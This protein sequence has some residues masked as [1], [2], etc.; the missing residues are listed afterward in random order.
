[1]S[2]REELVAFAEQA[3][4]DLKNTVA[5]IT[6]AVELAID[7]LPEGSDDDLAGLLERVQRNATKLASSLQELPAKAADWPLD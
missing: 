6:M 5:A 2:T 3:A 7:V 4:H 1:M